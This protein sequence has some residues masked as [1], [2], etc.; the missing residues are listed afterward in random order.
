MTVGGLDL[1][2]AN[3]EGSPRVRRRQETL[4]DGVRP[5]YQLVQQMCW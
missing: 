2:V 1:F 5:E 4:C 3:G